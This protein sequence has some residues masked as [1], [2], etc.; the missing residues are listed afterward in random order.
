M[1]VQYKLNKKDGKKIL[2][3]LGVACGGAGLTYL[4][5]VIPNVDFGVWSPI[6]VVAFS[7]LVNVARKFLKKGI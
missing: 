1:S 7:V 3:G 6:V 4:A 2:I 5:G